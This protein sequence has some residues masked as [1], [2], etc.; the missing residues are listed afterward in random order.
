MANIT[1]QGLVATTPRFLKT[2]DGKNIFCFRLAETSNKESNWFT[3]TAFD[4]LALNAV[5]SISKGD[6]VVVSGS[7]R[8]RDW[9]NGERAGT[10]A[11]IEVSTIG[12]DMTIGTST[13]SRVARAELYC[14]RCEAKESRLSDEGLCGG[15]FDDDERADLEH[16]ENIQAGA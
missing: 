1:V 6:R 11:E 13:F 14:S 3:V 10:S 2:S 9:D 8:I 4:E 12:H 15:C 5:Q 7:L 16:N